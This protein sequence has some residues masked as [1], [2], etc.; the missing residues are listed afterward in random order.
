[1]LQRIQS[2]YLLLAAV[3]VLCLLFF[4]IATFNV[5]TNHGTLHFET[6]VNG[7][8]KEVSGVKYKTDK[9]YMEEVIDTKSGSR[10]A[11][12]FTL[13]LVAVLVFFSLIVLVIFLYKKLD[14]QI[15]MTT[16]LLG[17]SVA[18]LISVFLIPGLG[19]K[20]ITEEANFFNE[21]KIKDTSVTRGLGTY[22][23]AAAIA[24][25]LLA[26]LKMKRDRKL[27]KSLDRLR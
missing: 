14:F 16:L 10:Y 1:M 6:A 22:L 9:E 4:P 15:T 2:L 23:P 12:F 26:L 21:I 25:I 20:F 18:L 13:G 7:M 24:F 27:L 19:M 5:E 11:K 8:K 3:S 17:I